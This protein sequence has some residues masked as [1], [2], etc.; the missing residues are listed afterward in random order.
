M[1]KRRFHFKWGKRLPKP[2]HLEISQTEWDGLTAR[3]RY[4]LRYPDRNKNQREEQ[5]R[6]DNLK[7]F[8]LT[9]EE[10]QEMFYNQNGVCAICGNPETKTRGGVVK[11]LAIDHDHLTGQVRGLLCQNCNVAL[12]YVK[13]NIH[14]LEAMIEY[15]RWYL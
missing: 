7:K 11:R 1:S 5:H 6:K 13:E 8:G 3:Q 14:T 2:E 9:L 15:L 10:Y 12:G 4:E